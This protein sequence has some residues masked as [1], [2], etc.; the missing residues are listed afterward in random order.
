MYK[1]YILSTLNQLLLITSLLFCCTKCRHETLVMNTSQNICRQ[2]QQQVHV[3]CLSTIYAFKYVRFEWHIHTKNV[4]SLKKSTTKNVLTGLISFY[5][6]FKIRSLLLIG[7]KLKA[8]FSE[9]VIP[10][11]INNTCDLRKI[12]RLMTINKNRNKKTGLFA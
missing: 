9:T 11:R 3:Q 5:Y 10:W 1:K 4:S 12:Y 8:D 7:M 2:F 6:V